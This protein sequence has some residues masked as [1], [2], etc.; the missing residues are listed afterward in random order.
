MKEDSTLNETN[1]H[2]CSINFDDIDLVS[3]TA[4]N[5]SL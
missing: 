1:W 3:L 5:E 4:S 2:P